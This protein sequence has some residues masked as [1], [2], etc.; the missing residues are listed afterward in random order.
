[1]AMEEEEVPTVRKN[2][3]VTQIPFN[4]LRHCI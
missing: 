3:A 1:M 4:Y 2:I